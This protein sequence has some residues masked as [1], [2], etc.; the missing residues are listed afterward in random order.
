MEKEEIIKDVEQQQQQ[1]LPQKKE[2]KKKPKI[3][4]QPQQKQQQQQQQIK[5]DGKEKGKTTLSKEDKEFF[6]KL[7]DKYNFE[8]KD[9]RAGAVVTRVGDDII[10]V[11]KIPSNKEGY[12]K[13]KDCPYLILKTN[14]EKFKKFIDNE[15]AEGMADDDEEDNIFFE[16]FNFSKDY[17]DE[18]EKL[19]A[20]SLKQ[21]KF[22]LNNL[23]K[24]KKGEE[25]EV[26]KFGWNEFKKFRKIPGI[27]DEKKYIEK[28]KNFNEETIKDNI[29]TS[30]AC[31]SRPERTRS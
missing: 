2:E 6:G 1:Q 21:K 11:R 17:F 9:R 3:Q 27:N 23:G 19:F 5:D 25:K 29:I 26:K 15:V 4:P 24:E 13:Y 18:N 28:L 30:I 16:Y 22:L 12:A 10:F 20:D 8:W 31:S 7:E 14:K